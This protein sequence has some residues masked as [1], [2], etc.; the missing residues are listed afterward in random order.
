MNLHIVALPHTY[1][2]PDCCG[3]AFTAKVLKFCKMMGQSYRI[4]VYAPEGPPI[5]GAELVPC[6]T[7]RKRETIFGKWDP[8][9]LPFWPTEQQSEDFMK[10]EIG[11][12]HV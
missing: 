7:T 1:V 9:K 2:S 11:R 8:Q 10:N 12:A 5:P 3:C 4:R 6:S